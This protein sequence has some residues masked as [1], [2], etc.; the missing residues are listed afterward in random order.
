MGFST[1]FS[2]LLPL[3]TKI[4]DAMVDIGSPPED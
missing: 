3:E 2:P 1:L 4:V